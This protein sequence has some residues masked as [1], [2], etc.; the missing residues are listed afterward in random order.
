MV[1]DIFPK[2]AH[3]THTHTTH[4]RTPHIHARQLIAFMHSSP[5]QRVYVCI[6]LC[7]LYS[8]RWKQW[9][10]QKV[11]NYFWK[12]HENIKYVHC[13][14]FFSPSSYL[15]PPSRSST[16]VIWC[17][18]VRAVFAN[19]VWL[20]VRRRL[21]QADSGRLVGQGKHTRTHTFIHSSFTTPKSKPVLN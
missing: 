15:P 18:F 9:K 17:A 3:T 10:F 19:G 7:G 11:A 5:A 4:T 12:D 2:Y 8:H 1:A 16:H 14:I 20:S 21:L 6:Y 13:S